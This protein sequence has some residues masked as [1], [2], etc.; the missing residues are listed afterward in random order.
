VS[1]NVIGIVSF[2]F[3]GIEGLCNV[4]SM[5]CLKSKHD[6]VVDYHMIV[7]CHLYNEKHIKT[8]STLFVNYKVTFAPN[9]ICT[10]KLFMAIFNDILIS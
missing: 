9:P 5:W 6:K 8:I 4:N 7:L 3:Y 10:S 2:S 1:P